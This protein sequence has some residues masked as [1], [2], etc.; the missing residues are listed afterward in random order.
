MKRSDRPSRSRP[1]PVCRSEYAVSPFHQTPPYALHALAD[2]GYCGCIG[3]LIRNDP[4]FVMARGGELAG[5]PR[6]FVGHSQQCML[7]GDCMLNNRDPLAIYKEAFE[8]AKSGHIF[9]GYLDHPIS[10]RYAYGW[11]NEERRV[12]IHKEFI[13][14]ILRSGDVL[15]C[16][17]D[18]AMDFLRFKAAVT[19]TLSCREK[20]I[21]SPAYLQSKW[22]IA[23]EYAGNVH[24]LPEFGASL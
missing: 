22:R 18:D 11:E 17:Q 7:H 12:T 6:G 3:G 24:C 9:F 14:H 2:A 13:H 5:M 21:E 15:S 4:E 10:Q 20:R 16:S 19:V 8:Q 23:V 1:S